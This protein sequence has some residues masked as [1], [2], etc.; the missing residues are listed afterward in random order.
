MANV[1]QRMNY[2]K[3]YYYNLSHGPK[4][5]ISNISCIISKDILRTPCAVKNEDR[6]EKMTR[7]L[8]NFALRS[9][10]IG[11]CQGLSFLINFILNMGFDE[12]E[13]FWLLVYFVEDI[14]PNEYYTNMMAVLADMRFL[15][16]VLMT[17]LPKL[18]KHLNKY[19]LD[20]VMVAIPYFIT[21]FTRTSLSVTLICIKLDL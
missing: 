2:D 8:N 7:I 19:N 16:K 13:S 1:R 9:S 18:A 20:L 10:R 11:Y 6:K 21:I 5:A 14:M 4:E 3:S 12:E 15:E 17:K